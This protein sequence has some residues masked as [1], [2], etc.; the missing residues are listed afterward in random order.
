MD[1]KDLKSFETVYEERSINQAAKKLYITPQGLG[2]NI[3]SLEKELDTVLFER[4]KQGVTPTE[5]AEL[6]YK[7]AS[8]LTQQFE[9]IKNEMKQLKSREVLLRI[10]CACGVFNVLPFKL[11]QDFISNNLPVKVA[12]CEYSNHEVKEMLCHSKL[13]YGFI[14]GE[15]ERKGIIKQKMA[16]KD[17]YLLV[18]EGHPFYEKQM[19]NIEML[20]EENLIVMNEHFNMFHDFRKACEVRGFTPKI[21]AKTADANCEHKFCRKGIGLAVVPGVTLED[22]S[23]EHMRAIPF[24]EALKWEVYGV[25][26]E[27]RAHDKFIKR[28]EAFL[29]QDL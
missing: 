29:M 15:W 22:F 20:K 16:S 1:I 18:Y 26:K 27:E 19:I 10:G 5:S 28:F 11:I 25:Y 8:S 7:K 6:L 4:D 17:M 24:Q 13:D 3:K 9:E 12:W 14:V 21:V 23:M 2:S